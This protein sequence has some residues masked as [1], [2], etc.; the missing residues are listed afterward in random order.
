M[1]PPPASLAYWLNSLGVGQ[2]SRLRS[3]MSGLSNFLGNVY[4]EN[5]EPEDSADSSP[6]SDG[7]KTSESSLE[8]VRDSM[9]ALLSSAEA[10][11]VDTGENQA[12]PQETAAPEVPDAP[13]SESNQPFRRP[14]HESGTH[15][16]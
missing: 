15:A 8:D 10:A 16:W 3:T 1:T 9:E 12:P 5:E 4:G 11:V 14:N 2:G 7:D 6:D 13:E